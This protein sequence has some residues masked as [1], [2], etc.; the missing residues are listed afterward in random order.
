MP[1]SV[2]TT[3]STSSACSIS[4]GP[5]DA[6]TTSL[7]TIAT[8]DAPVRV[9]VVGVPERPV[10]ERATRPDVDLTGLQ[11]RY[12]AGQLGEPLGDPRCAQN[13]GDRV[14]LF[15]G[16]VKDRLGLVGI[17]A[18]VPDDVEF[19]AA[20]GNDPDPLAVVAGELISHADAGQQHLFDVHRRYRPL[21]DFGLAW[22]PCRRAASRRSR[23]LPPAPAAVFCAPPL[24]C[25]CAEPS[26]AGPEYV[27]SAD[28][29]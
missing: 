14:G 1:S 15:V 28:S 11:P 20:P 17:V 9:R 7:R 18:R 6:S 12:F 29:V 24:P 10:R 27:N 21:A 5:G 22:R 23:R 2:P 19:A 13:L 4:A 8:I 3:T 26:S 16:E 25:T